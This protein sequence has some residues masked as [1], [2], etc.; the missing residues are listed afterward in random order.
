MKRNVHDKQRDGESEHA[1]AESFHAVLAEDPASARGVCV[2]LH[3]LSPSRPLAGSG[4]LS[5]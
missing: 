2:S 4:D 3:G 5:I 1:V